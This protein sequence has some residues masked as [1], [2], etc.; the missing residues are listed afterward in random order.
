MP[1]EHKLG[2]L[3]FSLVNLSL[4]F[5]VEVRQTTKFLEMTL[6][7]GEKIVQIR[8]GARNSLHLSAMGYFGPFNLDFVLSCTLL[9]FVIQI[10]CLH[11]IWKYDNVNALFLLKL[12]L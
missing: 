2:L 10:H 1:A 5:R 4:F 3:F 7:L 11:S 12:K 9:V 6:Y 8:L